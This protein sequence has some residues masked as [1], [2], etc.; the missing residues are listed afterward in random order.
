MAMGSG[1]HH[2]DGGASLVDQKVYFCPELSSIGGVLAGFLAP[3]RGRTALGIYRLPPPAD[4]SA[5]FGV[6]LNHPSH[7]PLED[8]HPRPALETLV[9]DARGDPEPIPMDGLP[10]RAGPEHIPDAVHHRS[11]GGSGSTAAAPW[12]FLPPLLLGQALLELSPEGPGKAE[13]IDAFLCRVMLSLT[14][15]I[16]FEDGDIGKPIL[17]EVR[18]SSSLTKRFSDRI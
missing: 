14:R 2:R 16:S 12:Y 15:R 5:L 11:I 3:Q 17:G 10:L 8:T 7:Q 4:A 1:E 9:D 13:V 6:V 18:L